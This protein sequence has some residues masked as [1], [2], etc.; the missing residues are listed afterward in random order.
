[1]SEYAVD[2]ADPLP[3]YYQVY[4]SLGARIHAG[5]FAP[6]D[7]LPA[8]RQLS[9]DYGVSRIT[10]IKAK[11]LLA[12][13]N[14]ITH[15]QGRGSFVM[16]QSEPGC[17]SEVCRVAFCLPTFADSYLAEILVGVARIAMQRDV[18]L[19]IVG[20]DVEDDEATRVRRAIDSGVGGV[21]LLPRARYPDWA[22]Y[23]KLRKDAF[24]L[25]FL[26]RYY[27]VLDIDRVVFDDDEAGYAL[28]KSLIEMGHRRIG[29]VTAAEIDASSVR[30]RLQGYRRALEEAGLLYDED[31]ICLDVYPDLE[32]SS[33]FNL[34]SSHLRLMEWLRRDSVT[35]IIAVNRYVALQMGMDL[36]RINAQ[37]MRAVIEGGERTGKGR[38]EIVTAAVSD[39][40]FDDCETPLAAV[41]IQS[42][43]R[44]GEQAMQVLLRRLR[45][46]S[47]L[48]T[49]HVALPMA[50][51]G[52]PFPELE[53]VSSL[54]TR[55]DGGS[56]H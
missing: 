22:L 13:D 28:A 1:M 24:P 3:K 5:E 8:E 11:D 41:A 25:V 12:R 39:R 36:M 48:P 46:G 30:G 9:A 26:D 50:L 2:P 21:L 45:Q 51:V 10:V 19:E 55:N 31:L 56:S 34:Q 42:G 43:E 53:P 6:G 40:P 32:P 23:E 37:M 16:D 7:A 52:S 15:Q 27:P 4:A 38:L 14:L 47:E 35:A 49:Q 29:I 17:G 33:L 18:Q 44:L 20:V 54:S